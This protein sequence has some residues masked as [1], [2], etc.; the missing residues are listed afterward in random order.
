MARVLFAWELGLGFG[1]LASMA[2][3]ADRLAIEG[4]EITF[5]LRSLARSRKVLTRPEYRFFQAP[6]KTVDTVDVIRLPSTYAEIL[7]NLGFGDSDELVAYV[8]GWRELFSSA[9]P[10]LLVADYSPTALLAAKT[11]GIPAIPI[12]TGFS[13]PAGAPSATNLRWWNPANRPQ[14]AEEKCVIDN[15]NAILKRDALAPIRY[16][17]QLFAADSVRDTILLTYPELDPFDRPN[18]RYYGNFPELAGVEPDWP[19]GDGPKVFAYLKP[20]RAIVPFLDHLSQTGVRLIL[21]MSPIPGPIE[22]RYANVPNIEIQKQFIDITSVAQQCE[23]AITNATHVTT[24]S[25]LLEG[26]PVMQIPPFMDQRITAEQVARL[27]AGVVADTANPE[28]CIQQWKRI[29]SSDSFAA[30]AQLFSSKYSQVSRRQQLEDASA[31][32]LKVIG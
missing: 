28:H 17:T 14:V 8:D 4:H 2:P 20:F 13:C 32:L 10:D 19:P 9:K 27:G 11:L 7:Y 1:H 6:I 29:S 25:M 22:A 18:E 5:A 23:I 31:A 21:R 16:P 26:T 3:L 24:A 12:G 15:I 30:A